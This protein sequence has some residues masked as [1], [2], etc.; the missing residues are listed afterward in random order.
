MRRWTAQER[1]LVLALTRGALRSKSGALALGWLWP[2]VIPAIQAC[3]YLFLFALVFGRSSAE[4][5]SV[6]LF[7]ILTF[8]PALAAMGACGGAIVAAGGI[9]TQIQVRPII[10]VAAAFL[11]SVWSLRFALAIALFVP[12][13]MVRSASLVL[14]LYPLI[15]LW[16]LLLIWAASLCVATIATFARDTQVVIPYVMQVVMLTSPVLYTVQILPP[17]LQ[18]VAAWNPV[19]VIFELFRFSVFQMPLPPIPSIVSSLGLTFVLLALAGFLYGK[20]SPRMTKVL[21]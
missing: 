2:L 4:Q 18:I 19:A 8:S 15:L 14:L 3:L 10:F 12:I 1:S 6:L 16:W 21:S 5:T 7:G 20:M 13:I 11:E 9:L 17:Y